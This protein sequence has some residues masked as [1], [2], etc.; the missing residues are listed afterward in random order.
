MLLRIVGLT[1]FGAVAAIPTRSVP[2]AYD[3]TGDLLAPV[4]LAAVN[5]EC[6]PEGYAGV[7]DAIH[8]AEA[9]TGL[10][11]LNGLGNGEFP[12]EIGATEGEQAMYVLNVGT[13]KSGQQIDVRVQASE[14]Y[15]VSSPAKNGLFDGFGQINMKG[16]LSTATGSDAALGDNKTEAYFTFTF[17]VGGEPYVME[18]GFLFTFFDFDDAGGGQFEECISF[19]ASL[20]ALT[21]EPSQL[22]STPVA[23]PTIFPPAEA[24]SGS[25]EAGSGDTGSGGRTR[26]QSESGEL[27]SGSG[28][29]AGGWLRYCSVPPGG[30]VKNPESPYILDEY[31]AARSLMVVAG[32]EGP[33]TSSFRIHLS[34]GFGGYR[35]DVRLD[36]SPVGSR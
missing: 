20:N 35:L 7:H 11:N 8:F 31:Q 23:A 16:T 5:G 27:G 25:G 15:Q 13:T 29:S 26:L 4:L 12:T 30:G 6:H 32:K 10:S 18:E 2:G 28:A 1:L 17:M 34:V 36:H 14:T 21:W 9:T 19:D 24:G 33:K 3:G 22:A